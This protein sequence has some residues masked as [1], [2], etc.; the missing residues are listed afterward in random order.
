MQYGTLKV[1]LHECV[2]LSIWFNDLD[3]QQALLRQWRENRNQLQQATS[4][5]HLS[6][7]SKIVGV[8]L[9][10]VR[11]CG[12]DQGLRAVQIGADLFFE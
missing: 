4:T 9:L 10:S 2:R 6:Q 1:A 5:Q 3:L 11:N 7:A 8:G 12:V